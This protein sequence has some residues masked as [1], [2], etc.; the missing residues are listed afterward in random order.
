MVEQGTQNPVL[1][2]L[3]NHGENGFKEILYFPLNFQLFGKEY[4]SR[5]SVTISCSLPYILQYISHFKSR[6]GT[7]PAILSTG[8]CF[9]QPQ[10][11]R[12]S[13]QA[14]NRRALCQK[15]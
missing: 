1:G 4:D 7:P 5:R 2:T 13:W 6:Q 14:T 11:I 8:S 10:K 12:S 9:P 15:L 3:P